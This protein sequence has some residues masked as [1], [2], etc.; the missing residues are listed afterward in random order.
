MVQLPQENKILLTNSSSS[1]AN[2][3][4]VSLSN[5]WS[6][7][8]TCSAGV[9][10]PLKPSIWSRNLPSPSLFHAHVGYRTLFVV[11]RV[12][13]KL[14]QRINSSRTTLQ[15]KYGLNHIAWF[16][17]VACCNSPPPSIRAVREHSVAGTTHTCMHGLR[18]G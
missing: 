6:V 7:N 15:Q 5:P 16:E 14:V 3:T 9:K 11:T 17:A 1:L 10:R 12:S 2:I 4:A 13:K 18:D 8:I